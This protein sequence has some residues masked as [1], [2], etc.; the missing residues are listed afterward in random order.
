MNDVKYLLFGTCLLV[1]VL[2][3]GCVVV[4]GVPGPPVV[5]EIEIGYPPPPPPAVVITRP[6]RPS[7][8]HIW[9][10][11]N[12]VVS[13]GAWVWAPGHW[14]RRPHRHSAWVRGRANR[15]GDVWLWTPGHWH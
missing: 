2:A 13:G 7:G 8:F 4:S 3:S 11:G 14:A 5:G 9:I 15:R 12:Y 1:V 6:P 10:E